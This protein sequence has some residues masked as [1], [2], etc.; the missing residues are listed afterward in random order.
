[1]SLHIIASLQLLRFS[2]ADAV[3]GRQEGEH[4]WMTIAWN[5]CCRSRVFSMSHLQAEYPTIPERVA[6]IITTLTSG[7]P[8]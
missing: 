2:V 6:H 3:I 4:I 7:L 1:M 8:A 5:G